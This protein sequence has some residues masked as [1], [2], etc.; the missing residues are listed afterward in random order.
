VH[1]I[2]PDPNVG[3]FIHPRGD[4]ANAD[5]MAALDPINA[6][7]DSAP[8][9]VWRL[10]GDGN[11]ATEIVPDAADPQLLVNMSVSRDVAAL[12]AF[13]YANG[14]HIAL[15]RRR[16]EWF[17]HMAV[18]QALWWVPAGHMPSVAE[19]MARLKHLAEHDPTAHAFTFKQ[20]FAPPADA[21][22]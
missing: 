19:G 14:D 13:V 21:A 20:K 16:R 2:G 4:A 1:L 7:A 3:R 8:G 11:D 22:Q 9:F 5:F 18:M 12:R 15:M 6:Q 10:V 17:D